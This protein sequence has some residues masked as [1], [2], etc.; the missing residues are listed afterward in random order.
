[1]KKDIRTDVTGFKNGKW[2]EEYEWLSQDQIQ[3]YINELES[4]EALRRV[5][6]ARRQ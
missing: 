6:S 4:Q 3:E 5:R 1:M 2:V